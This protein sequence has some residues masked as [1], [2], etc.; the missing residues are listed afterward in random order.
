MG[1]SRPGHGNGAR[2]PKQKIEARNTPTDTDLIEWNEGNKTG[3]L[4]VHGETEGLSGTAASASPVAP[5]GVLGRMSGLVNRATRQDEQR[6]HLAEQLQLLLFA[7]P[8]DW[9]ARGRHQKRCPARA[10]SRPQPFV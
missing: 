9:T 1:V 10:D 3:D 6:G 8:L 5:E 4:G 2:C 7:P